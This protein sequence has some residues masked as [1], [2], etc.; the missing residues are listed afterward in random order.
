[1]NTVF[2]IALWTR[3]L[4]PF[5]ACVFCLDVGERILDLISFQGWNFACTYACSGSLPPCIWEQLLLVRCFTANRANGYQNTEK[6]GEENRAGG[7]GIAIRDTIQHSGGL[8]KEERRSYYLKK[9]K[10][11][12]E[13]GSSPPTR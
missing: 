2:C 6:T 11:N 12:G 7:K 4:L 5:T 1:M 9:K 3:C 13:M 10:K 8:R